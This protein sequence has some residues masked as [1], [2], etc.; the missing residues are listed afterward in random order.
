MVYEYANRLQS[1]GHSVTVVHPRNEAAQRGTIQYVKSHLWK[2]KLQLKQRP[3]ISWFDLHPG[4]RLLLM[5]DLREHFIPDGDTIIA[6]AYNT[7]FH[8]DSYPARKGRKFYLIQS[9]ETW[10]GPE[11]RVRASW[12]LPLH[13]VVVSRWLLRLAQSMGEA[14]RVTH[15]PPGLEFSQLK[16]SRP[17]SERQAARVGM[18]AHPNKIKGTRDGL[19]AL[20][21]ARERVPA[22]QAVMFGT[23]S[24]D[25]EIPSWIEY[26]QLPSPG[27]LL[28]IYNSCRI[29]LHPSW[30]EGWGLPAAEAMA[31]GCAL[32]AAA[33]EGVH[34]FARD[35]QNALLA[36]IKR[37]DALAE[38]LT[39]ALVNDDLRVRIAESGH[40][41][42]QRF[43]WDRA[44][45][46]LEKLLTE[47][48]AR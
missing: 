47:Q 26:V 22:L 12:S 33:N 48:Q 19:K 18:L 7:A 24:R 25:V 45:N 15:I 32:V 41:Q 31:C 37:P 8:V 2:Y 23:S 38:R 46:S 21:I 14:E 34:E 13:K 5:P 42:I 43:T 11:E 4:V 9:Y 10:Q 39:E 35:G 16:I 3:L 30:I 1:R 28:E 36:P 20:E 27:R 40:Q 17:I 6:T 29:F 44:V